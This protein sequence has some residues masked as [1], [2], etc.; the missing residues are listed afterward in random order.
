MVSGAVDFRDR[1]R[2]LIARPFNVQGRNRVENRLPLG[3]GALDQHEVAG[4]IGAN[5]ARP[6]DEVLRHPGD[7]CGRGVRSGTIETPKPGCVAPTL[8]RPAPAAPA[9]E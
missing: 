1:R 2:R 8:T 3:A 6:R 9:P 4:L 5:C 7:R